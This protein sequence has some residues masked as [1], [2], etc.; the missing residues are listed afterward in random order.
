MIEGATEYAGT[1]LSSVNRAGLGCLASGFG[2]EF[3]IWDSDL[4]F[5]GT[6]QNEVRTHARELDERVRAAE[7]C[8][9]CKA[10]GISLLAPYPRIV[11]VNYA[12]Q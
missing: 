8:S 3:G 12:P 9:W 10:S 6:D 4:R 1:R 11:Q 7:Y 5:Y 2:S